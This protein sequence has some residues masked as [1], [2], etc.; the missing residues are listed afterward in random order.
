MKEEIITG[1][2]EVLLEELMHFLEE[3]IFYND[4][5][6]NLDVV[7]DRVEYYFEIYENIV[8]NKLEEDEL[9]LMIQKHYE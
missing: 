1:L 3:E 8:L 9:S 4:A 5:N 2:K 6:G 7:L